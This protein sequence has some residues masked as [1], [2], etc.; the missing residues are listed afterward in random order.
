MT[1]SGRSSVE[2]PS[3][4]PGGRS[5]PPDPAAEIAT[6]VV[7]LAGR[8]AVLPGYCEQIAE[9]PVEHRSVRAALAV[10]REGS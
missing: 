4:A 7:R 5:A 1:T 3:Q 10:A 2:H 6:L 8:R 9:Q